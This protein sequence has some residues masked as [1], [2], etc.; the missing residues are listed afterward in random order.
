MARITRDTKRKFKYKKRSGIERWFLLL[1]MFLLSPLIM[2]WDS[3]RKKDL[4]DR[5]WLYC[6]FLFTTVVMLLTAAGIYTAQSSMYK[7]I[8]LLSK[9]DGN[10]E[11]LAGEAQPII[12]AINKYAL[13]YNVDPYLV[14]AL[15]RQESNFN[16][17]A[18]SR[19]G[20]KG[21][22][23]LMPSVWND[24]SNSTCSGKHHSRFACPSAQCIYEIDANVRVGVMYLRY[25][26]D[27]YHG[28][29]DLALEAYNAGLGNVRP[30]FEPKYA[31]TRSYITKTVNHWQE[32]RRSYLSQKIAV[33]ERLNTAV[34]WLIY[35][36]L[37]CWLN[38]FWWVF[39]KL[40]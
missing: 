19:A 13:E 32:L 28:R 16:R 1:V 8:E 23:Q 40:L 20:A 12:R 38:L 7:T 3:F 10:H 5:T 4:P 31:E 14:Y 25:L 36:T 30:G 15:I 22:M 21:L 9:H 17:Y 2:F 33:A 18:T 35:L 39:R 34:K 6:F 29:V 27:I 26:M 11:V 24:Y 37:F